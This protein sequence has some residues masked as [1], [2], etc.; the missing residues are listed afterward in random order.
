[1]RV[2]AALNLLL[3][4]VLRHNERMKAGV[5]VFT[6]ALR[7]L[8]FQGCAEGVRDFRLRSLGPA[9]LGRRWVGQRATWHRPAQ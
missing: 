8:A 1:V 7:E 5:A 4:G 6:A 9:Q 2:V 3:W